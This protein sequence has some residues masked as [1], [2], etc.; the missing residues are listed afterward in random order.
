MTHWS[1]RMSSYIWR[2]HAIELQSISFHTIVCFSFLNDL[3]LSP[4][5]VIVFKNY[6]NWNFKD[7]YYLRWLDL[8]RICILLT[9]LTPTKVE[10]SLWNYKGKLFFKKKTLLWFVAGTQEH[11]N[12]KHSFRSSLKRENFSNNTKIDLLT[13]MYRHHA[14]MLN[15]G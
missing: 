14:V 8:V 13:L 12:F 15:Q 11:F 5:L 9:L 4:Y 3:N 2:S 1:A 10:S 6:H 7:E